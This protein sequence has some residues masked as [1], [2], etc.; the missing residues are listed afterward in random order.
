MGTWG[1]GVPGDCKESLWMHRPW[2]MHLR[3][4]HP[5]AQKVGSLYPSP[6]LPSGEATSPG[7]GAVLPQYFSPALCSDQ[8]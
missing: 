5:R 2:M 4:I 8:R 3:V 1:S 7:G 6:H